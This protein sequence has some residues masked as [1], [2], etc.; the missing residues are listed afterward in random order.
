[1]TIKS[2]FTDYLNYLEIEKNRSIKTI[3]N[4]DRYLRRFFD[5]AKI[6]SPSSISNDVVR[7][8][9]L[10]LNRITPPLKKITQAYHL[11]ALRN[12]LK[13][14]AKRDI[15]TLTAD[16]IELGKIGDRHIDF[17]ENE[18]IERLLD[19]ANGNSVKNL[20]DKALLE[21]LFSTGLRVSELCSLNKESVNL[22]RGEFAV[23]GKGDK[24]RVVFL[25]EPARRS[26]ENYIAKREDMSEA[27]FA[28]RISD[29]KQKANKDL[30]ITPRTV[31]RT[32]SRRRS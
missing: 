27:L 6:N 19:S 29:K 30:R 25:S 10:H 18:E 9:R 2:L 5:Y 14:L 22:K 16:K 15:K 7:N 23:R 28:R 8:Y 13:Y 21:L 17:L 12:F 20:R 4:Y 32:L 31:Q 24:I 11:I 1:M 3:E 26:L